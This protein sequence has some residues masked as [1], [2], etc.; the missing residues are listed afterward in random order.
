MNLTRLRYFGHVFAYLSHRRHVKFLG[1]VAD[2]SAHRDVFASDIHLPDVADSGTQA[3]VYLAVQMQL[4]Q[5]LASAV[6][7]CN[8]YVLHINASS[9]N[10]II[11]N[12]WANSSQCNP[13]NIK[14][15]LF[16]VHD[17]VGWSVSVCGF[18]L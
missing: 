15:V 18:I 12:R 3:M 9:T 8:S 14:A 16:C 1:S 10:Y 7:G 2:I 4:L 13:V 11:N 6:I 17:L 5:P